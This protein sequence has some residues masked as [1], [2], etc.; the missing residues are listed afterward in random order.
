MLAHGSGLPK[1]GI[2]TKRARAALMKAGL[3]ETQS[4]QRDQ[5]FE[6]LDDLTEKDQSDR[7]LA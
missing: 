4:F 2:Q 1:K 3:S 7:K 5:L 6:L